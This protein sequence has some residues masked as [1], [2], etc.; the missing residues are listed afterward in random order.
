[1]LHLWEAED[2][3][4]VPG[5]VHQ[6]RLRLAALQPPR[7]G[8]RHL[9]LLR[10][11]ARLPGLVLQLFLLCVRLGHALGLEVSQLLLLLLPGLLQL[12]APHCLLLLEVVVVALVGDEQLVLQVDHLLTHAVEELLVVAHYQQG[13]LPPLQV[14]VQPDD[15]VEVQVVGGLVQHE[16]GGL[17]EQRPGQTDAHAPAPREELRGPH[18]HLRIEPQSEQNAASSGLRRGCPY[19]GQLLVQFAQPHV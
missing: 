9:L 12:L 11:R 15:R 6:L 4:V 10:P 2:H 8:R 18:L 7:G 3:A 5:T 17:D 16:Q 1:M 13:L 14:V 19:G